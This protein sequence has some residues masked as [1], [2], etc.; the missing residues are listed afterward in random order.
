MLTFKN[1]DVYAVMEI[2]L[3]PGAKEELAGL[4]FQ[5]F[6][7]LNMRWQIHRFIE[8]ELEIKSDKVRQV[9]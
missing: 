7:I 5:P 6:H 4:Y 3:G 9:V 1:V 8:E 2:Q